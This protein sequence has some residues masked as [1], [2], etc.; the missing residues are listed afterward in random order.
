MT[1]R[2]AAVGDIHLSEHARGTYR[3]RLNGIEERADVLLVAG[4]LT[5]HGTVEEGQV[6]ADEFRGLAIPVVFVLGNHDYH[7]DAEQEI[8]AMLRATGHFVLDDSAEVLLGGRLGVAGGK[9]FGGGFAGK[10]ANEFGEPETKAFVR[11]TREIADRWRIAL[12][13]LDTQHRIVLSHYAPVKDTLAGEP[14]EIYP[15][16]G[17]YLLA[18]AADAAGADLIIHGHAHAGTEK[19]ATPGGIRVRNVA[20]P[21]LGRSYATYGL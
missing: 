13:G 20:L 7:S 8:M 12:K 4:D 10:C 15:F 14:P 17:S 18:E 21:V 6:I 19:G 5:R 3:A 16:L 9:G 1:I 11:H 2:V